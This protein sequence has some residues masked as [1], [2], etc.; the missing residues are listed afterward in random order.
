M[1]KEL[2]LEFDLGLLLVH[3]PNSIEEESYQYASPVRLLFFWMRLIAMILGR[4]DKE[5]ALL[6][7]ARD[8]IQ[9]LINQ[10]FTRPT[11]VVDDGVVAELPAI[12]TNLPREKPVSM[13]T[14][15][16]EICSRLTFF[17]LSSFPKQLL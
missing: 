6:S 9:L 11:R 4:N 7:N 15:F 2:P 3:D 5:Q 13:T 10:I 12:T 14:P 1:S 8:G 17:L 16:P